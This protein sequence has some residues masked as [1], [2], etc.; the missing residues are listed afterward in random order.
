MLHLVGYL[1]EY[2]KAPFSIKTFLLVKRV[3]GIE[4]SC[5]MNFNWERSCLDGFSVLAEVL[6]L[7]Y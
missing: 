2:M 4:K 1:L 6:T 5:L 7:S 3:A